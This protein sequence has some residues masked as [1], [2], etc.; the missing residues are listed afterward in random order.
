MILSY[1]MAHHDTSH[2]LQSFEIQQVKAEMM[3]KLTL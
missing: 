2:A 3:T 1:G